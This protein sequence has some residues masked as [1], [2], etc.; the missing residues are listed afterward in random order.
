MKDY[1]SPY[2]Q[3]I[4]EGWQQQGSS[5]YF[6]YSFDGELKFQE[7]LQ[8]PDNTE[9]P[10]NQQFRRAAELYLLMAGASY[11]KAFPTKELVYKGVDHHQAY[12]VEKTYKQG[13]GEFLYVNQLNPEIIGSFVDI[14]GD[15]PAAEPLSLSGA[16]V[17]IGG[18]KD[19]LVSVDLLKKAGKDFSTFR[20]NS[21]PWIDRQM[22]KIGAPSS[23]IKRIIDPNLSAQKDNGGLGGHIP[24]TAIVSAAALIDAIRLGKASVITSSEASANIPNTEYAGM[25]I[26]HQYSKSMEL[27]SE[28]A[29][30]IRKFVC[31]SINYFSLLRPWTELKIVEYFVD[32]LFDEYS[33]LW[34][35]SN[36]NFKLGA[37]AENPSWDADYS[38]KTL[39][40]F[41]MFA[42]FV[43]PQKLIPEMGD[44]YFAD[45]KYLQ[46]W[47]ELVGNKGIKP[48]ECVA[49]IDEM[50]LAV[51][52]AQN[53]GWENAKKIDVSDANFDYKTNQPH[54]IPEE[55]AGL[56]E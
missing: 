11:Y 54:A 31:P 8:W 50:K 12:L 29:D 16:L 52:M 5:L 49:D 38:A 26:N 1:Q 27:E 37:N 22:Q 4:F 42:A 47:D 41:G 19:S 53:N 48:L 44:D 25:K 40:V 2:K 33:G 36:H 51:R 46:T 35:S 18:G 28:L 34:S 17:M 39:S 45:D 55:Y 24:I 21:L 56:V 10:N 23:S 20:I 32:N 15:N 6:N 43:E 9:L 13:F 7:V 3:F 30:Y 14:A